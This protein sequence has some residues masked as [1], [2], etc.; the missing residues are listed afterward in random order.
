MYLVWLIS[1]VGAYIQGWGL[2]IGKGFVLVNR[3]LLF[4]G[5]I[6]GELIFGVVRYTHDISKYM[7][8]YRNQQ[9]IGNAICILF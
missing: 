7:E 4:R 2:I 9:K 6:F 3:G 1:G 8:I 5:L